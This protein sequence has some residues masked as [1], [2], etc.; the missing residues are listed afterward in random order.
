[1]N[2]DTD[3]LI[4][5]LI[6]YKT[7]VSY[8][9]GFILCVA[10]FI[11]GY[12]VKTCPPKSEVCKAEEVT[13][14]GLNAELLAKDTTRTTQL[15]EQRDADR[16]ICDARVE[17]AKRNQTASNEFLECSDICAL[18]SQCERAGRCK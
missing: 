15:R 18:F 11:G 6:K 5:L 7:Q 17:E 3:K 9:I 2:V 1:M 10:C 16:L 14:R 13:I 8:L 4:T 12:S